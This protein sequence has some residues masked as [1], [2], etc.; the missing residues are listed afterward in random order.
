MSEIGRCADFPAFG[1]QAD[2][3]AGQTETARPTLQAVKHILQAVGG[4]QVG[5][6]MQQAGKQRF[7][8]AGLLH[9]QGD[10]FFQPVDMVALAGQMP[11][12]QRHG[13]AN[14]MGNAHLF[15]QPRVTDKEIRVL[16]QKLHHGVVVKLNACDSLVLNAL[17]R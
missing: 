10:F 2:I 16:Q 5:L 15:H 11:L 14:G 8:G 9:Q 13:T 7:V 1:K 17:H 6:Q 4:G 3:G 12:D